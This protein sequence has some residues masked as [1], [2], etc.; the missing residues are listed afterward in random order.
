MTDL[1]LINSVGG[2]TAVTLVD[3]VFPALMYR[4]LIQNKTDHGTVGERL[5]VRLVMV[6]MVVGVIL[7]LIGVWDS[8]VYTDS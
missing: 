3:F 8:I 6:L 5:E 4:A 1:G 2:G 7:G